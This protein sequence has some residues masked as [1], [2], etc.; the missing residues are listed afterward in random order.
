MD[1]LSAANEPPPGDACPVPL[2][3]MSS[4]QGLVDGIPGALPKALAHTVGRAGIIGAGLFAAGFR[5]KDLFKGAF[6]GA[7]AIETFVLL[8]LK[9]KSK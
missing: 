7:I 1:T 8:Y 4:A 6:A 5:G 2:P 9:L 3:S